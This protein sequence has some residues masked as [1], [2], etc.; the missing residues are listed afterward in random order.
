MSQHGGRDGCILEGT[1][2]E[3]LSEEEFSE[4]L[5]GNQGTAF[6]PTDVDRNTL[7][8]MDMWQ[9]ISGVIAG[10]YMYIRTILL[11]TYSYSIL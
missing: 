1:L 2:K 4:S 3:A 8:P 5:G 9:S 11:D 10:T 7:E 6:I